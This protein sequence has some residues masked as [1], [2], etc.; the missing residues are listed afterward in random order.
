MNR[1]QFSIE[2]PDADTE[3]R[4]YIAVR[5]VKGMVGLCVSLEDGGDVEVFMT[6]EVCEK[7]VA[8]MR[9][10]IAKSQPDGDLS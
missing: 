3:E 5:G 7:V 4:T 9:K 1:K 8:A 2:F 6:S 10:A